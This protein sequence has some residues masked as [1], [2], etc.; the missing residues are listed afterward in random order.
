MAVS[1]CID[2]G[3]FMLVSIFMASIDCRQ[4]IIPGMG[5]VQQNNDKKHHW[6]YNHGMLWVCLPK[7]PELAQ[8][9]Q[10]SMKDTSGY[11]HR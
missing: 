10:L 3:I 6:I 8:L 5:P 11:K 4:P 7:T 2:S 1:D 9:L